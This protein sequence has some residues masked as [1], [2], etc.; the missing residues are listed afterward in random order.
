MQAFRAI[1]AAMLLVLAVPG[2]SA[3]PGDAGVLENRM[4]P[5]VDPGDDFYRYVNGRWLAR[6]AIPPDRSNYGTFTIIHE[7]TQRQLRAIIES[8]P[9]IG[10]SADPDVDEARKIAALHRSYM[11]LATIEQRGVAPIK[12]VLDSILGLEDRAALP[13]LLGELQH[14]GIDLPIGLSV[15]RD[16]RAPSEYALYLSQ[17]GLGMPERTY[18]LSDKARFSE[19][20]SAYRGHVAT[21][22]ALAGLDRAQ[23]RADAVVELE[24]ALAEAHWTRVQSRDRQATYNPAPLSELAELAPGFDWTAF[25]TALNP[26]VPER[27]IVRQPEALTATAR[28]LAEQPLF[29][30]QSWLV[31]HTL[32]AY[33]PYLSSPLVA[34]HFDFHKARLSGIEQP[35]AR[36]KRALGLVERGMG[37]ALGERYVAE[38]FPA[39][40]RARVETMVDYLTRA[41]RSRIQTLPWMSKSTRQ[42]ALAKLD[43]FSTKIGYPEEWRDYSDLVIKEE[44]L[45]GNVIRIQRHEF[46]YHYGKLG[47]P[48]DDDEWFMT[49]QTVNAY[50][51]PGGN[52]IVFPAAILQPPFFDPSADDAVNYGAIG[53]VIGHEIGHGFDDQGSRFDG[54]GRM[55]NWWTEGDR[56][57]FEARTAALVE[58]YNAFCPLPDH[59][60]NGALSLGEN[61]GDLGGLSI[62]Y[63]ALQ[64]AMDDTDHQPRND[65]L[66]RGDIGIAQPNPSKATIEGWTPAQRFFIGWGQ[67]WA[68][69]YRDDEL[70]NRLN[71]GPHAPD[72]YRTNGVVRNIDAWYGAFGVE[73][74]DALYLPPDDRVSIW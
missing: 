47:Q 29:R 25:F 12:P 5:A 14:M 22:L 61:I 37:D 69:K 46:A 67:I 68:R 70:I 74:G 55:R 34:E 66:H 20:R 43:R 60:V 63:L 39:S 44:D 73:R 6:T 40:H 28:L 48:V 16:A 57:R 32:A 1:T 9:C 35:K 17:S 65:D 45:L 13:A 21:M 26:V 19:L 8:L 33:A 42:E 64:M 3:A 59:C 27:V 24:S 50:Y 52:E 72:R 2:F 49:P 31:H 58:Q 4:E 38:H 23:A 36:W 53:A 56:Q 51:S 41:Y 11:D 30:L 71:N 15:Y 62:A 10:D 7:R 18:Y 54:E